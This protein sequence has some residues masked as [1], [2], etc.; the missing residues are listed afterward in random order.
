MLRYNVTW[1]YIKPSKSDLACDWAVRQG[2]KIIA[3]SE[4]DDATIIT[5]RCHWAFVKG[6]PA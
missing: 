6:Q 2:G 3:T 5:D 1:S 4:A